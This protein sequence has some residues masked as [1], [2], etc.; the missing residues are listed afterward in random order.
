MLKCFDVMRVIMLGVVADLDEQV[1]A[2]PTPP[3]LKPY[4]NIKFWP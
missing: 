1:L 4:I 2:I 3:I